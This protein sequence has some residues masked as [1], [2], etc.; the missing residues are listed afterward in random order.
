MSDRADKS[1]DQVLL[2]LTGPLLGVDFGTVRV[3]LAASDH[4]QTIAAPLQTYTR[5]TQALDAQFLQQFVRKHGIVGLVIGLPAHLSGQEGAKAK[6]ARQFGQW[7]QKTT[8]LP[9]A[10]VDERYSSVEAWN[11]LKAGG[12]KA[13][14]RKKHVDKVAAQVI[15]QAF[16]D[17]RLVKSTVTLDPII[18]HEESSNPK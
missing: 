2:P 6:Q 11:Y 17:A 7:L 18:P 13:A 15:L 3:G 8:Q 16:L 4:S 9:L 12:L 14:Q 1:L 5:Q 10:F